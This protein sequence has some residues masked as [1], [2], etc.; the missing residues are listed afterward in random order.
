M[1]LRLGNDLHDD[2]SIDGDTP[3][4]K[5][6]RRNRIEIQLKH[7]GQLDQRLRYTSDHH[8]HRARVE[9]WIQRVRRNILP[10]GARPIDRAACS[11][12]RGADV[13]VFTDP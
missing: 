10:R 8:G 13:I 9:Q 4:T 6:V 11:L 5:F 1:I 2:Q 12:R 3:T 7:P